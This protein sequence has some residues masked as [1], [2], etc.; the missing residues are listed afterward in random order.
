MTGFKEMAPAPRCPRPW[1]TKRTLPP[2]ATADHAL[3]RTP[4][5][6]SLLLCHCSLMELV[7]SLSLQ[8]TLLTVICKSVW[9]DLYTQVCTVSVQVAPA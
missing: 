5:R 2:V 1:M 9:P 3:C 7:Y 4:H 8:I 6:Y